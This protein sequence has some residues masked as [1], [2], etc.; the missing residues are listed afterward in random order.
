MPARKR[1]S[2]RGRQIRMALV[3]A[4]GETRVTQAS[5]RAHLVASAH[6]HLLRP[7]GQGQHPFLRAQTGCRETVDRKAMDLR[8]A[9]QQAFHPQR[10]EQLRQRL[11]NI[12]PSG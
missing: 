12:S 2:K 7:R 5:R 9:H 3:K 6:W 8:S 4:N 1:I 11:T 10:M